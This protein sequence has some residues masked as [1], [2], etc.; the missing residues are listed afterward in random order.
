M[1]ILQTGVIATSSKENEARVPI[2]PRHLESIPPALRQHLVLEHGYSERF[3][4]SD[5][6]LRSFGYRLATRHQLLGESA[7]VL[8]PKPQAQD[9]LEMG[10]GTT[11]WGWPHCVQQ[12]EITQAAIDRRLT[13]LAFEAM[14][15]WGSSGE[16]QLH[17]FYK[18]NELAGYCSV[19]HAL[20]LLGWDGFYGPPRS[21]VVLGFGSV[22]RGA[23]YALQGRGVSDITIYTQRPSHLV[24]DQVFGCCYGRM[25]RSTTPQEGLIA[26]WSGTASPMIDVLAAAD[27]IV[28][29]TLQDTDRPLMYLQPGEEDRLKPGSLIIDVSCDEGMGFPFARPT[30]FE[31]PSF[32]VGT[33]NTVAYYAVDHSPSYLWDSASWEI[34]TAL[35]PYLEAVMSGPKAWESDP[36]IERSIEIRAGVIRNDKILSFQRRSPEYPHAVLEE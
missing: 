35:L 36:T 29:G 28:N 15:L 12:A 34:S 3:G 27:L 8:L 11:L 1:S 17:T 20:E 9:L 21:C 33:K 24:R 10:E 19:L 30:S 13:L 4:I 22:S 31:N 14:Y 25:R 6:D 32:R 5:E 23:V 7:I 18:N 2:H 16:R 26:E